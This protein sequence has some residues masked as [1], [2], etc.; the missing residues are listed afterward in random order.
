VGG[1]RRVGLRKEME[2]SGIEIKTD[3][4][5]KIVQKK[6]EVQQQQQQL[7]LVL[8]ISPSV[9]SQDKRMSNLFHETT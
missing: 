5:V 1:D 9:S 4:Y 6:K 8:N 2:V 3:S 7:E